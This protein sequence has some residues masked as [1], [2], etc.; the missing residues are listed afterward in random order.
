MSCSGPLLSGPPYWKR[1]KSMAGEF[2]LLKGHHQGE[3]LAD[4]LRG[5]LLEHHGLPL[6][7][8][9]GP[10]L[11]D[12]LRGQKAW[13]MAAAPCVPTQQQPF[14]PSALSQ[15]WAELGPLRGALQG[16]VLRFLG[17]R[18]PRM[19]QVIAGPRLLLEFPVSWKEGEVTF[20][21]PSTGDKGPQP[22]ELS[23]FLGVFRVLVTRRVGHPL[24][25]CP[26]TGCHFSPTVQCL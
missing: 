6:S 12:D 19:G 26:Q 1:S 8:E 15:A 23:G 13:R 24:C 17:Q 11:P 5:L 10:F 9:K 25:R 21:F 7:L 16:P 3:A 22:G 4:G 20:L 2:P 14:W 18:V